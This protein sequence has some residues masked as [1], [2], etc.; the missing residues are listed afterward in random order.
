MHRY[1]EA[2]KTTGPAD[3]QT[4]CQ[5]DFH[6]PLDILAQCHS[7]LEQGLIE[8]EGELPQ[9]LQDLKT[10]KAVVKASAFGLQR[11]FP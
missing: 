4:L 3:I 5:S 2:L 10:S 7:L 11:N 1:L 9:T 8:V 6:S